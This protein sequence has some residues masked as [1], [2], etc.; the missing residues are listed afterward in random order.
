MLGIDRPTSIERVGLLWSGLGLLGAL[1]GALK[2]HQWT[3]H[4]KILSLVF[5]R[6]ISA[7]LLLICICVTS[8]FGW[9]GVLL[10]LDDFLHGAFGSLDD[11]RFL[12]GTRCCFSHFLQQLVQGVGSG[13][14]AFCCCLCCCCVVGGSG[15]GLGP[16]LV[17]HHI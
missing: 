17:G 15:C 8:D 14:A 3:R 10:A 16:G 7:K 13:E 4:V 1:A 12:L 2:S 6:Y 5:R 11:S 9:F